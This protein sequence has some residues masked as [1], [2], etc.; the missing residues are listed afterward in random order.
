MLFNV[1]RAMFAMIIVAS[2]CVA[3]C[4]PSGVI[5]SLAMLRVELL[6]C[7]CCALFAC[8]DYRSDLLCVVRL[9]GVALRRYAYNVLGL[10]VAMRRYVMV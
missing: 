5:G 4:E 10:G 8:A 6:R 9:F 7:V 2:M 1:Q 3:C